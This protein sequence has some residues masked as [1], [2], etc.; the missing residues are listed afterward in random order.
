MLHGKS[1]ENVIDS[2][3][4]DEGKEVTKSDHDN[5]SKE[6]FVNSEDGDSDSEENE[7][8]LL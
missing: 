1:D 7:K 8:C 6:E 2:G 4:S 5:E 3:E